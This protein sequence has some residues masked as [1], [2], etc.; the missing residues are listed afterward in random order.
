MLKN[1]VKASASDFEKIKSA[2]I[3]GGNMYLFMEDGNLAGVIQSV[4]QVTD[5]FVMGLILG[6]LVLTSYNIWV[7]VQRKKKRV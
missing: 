6:V 2:Y 4:M 1:L 5:I 3:D 7:S